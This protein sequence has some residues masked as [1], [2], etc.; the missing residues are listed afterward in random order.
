MNFVYPAFLFSLFL[1][2]IPV[3]IHLVNLRKYKKVYF[4]NVSLLQQIQTH[5][6]KKR[7]LREWLILAARVLFITFLV[8]AFAQPFIKQNNTANQSG[9]TYVSLYIDNSFSMEKQGVNGP[10]LAEAIRIAETVIKAY[11]PSDK[12]QILTNDFS[13]N[14]MR[15]L[16][17][18]EALA[19][20]PE[21]QTS[22]ALY[23]V[24]QV[25]KKQYDLLKTYSGGNN[26]RSYLISDFASNLMKED[27]F[28]PD[29]SL[30]IVALPVQAVVQNN[31][32]FDSIWCNSPTVAL[33]VPTELGFRVVNSGENEVVDQPIRVFVNGEQKTPALVTIPAKSK[34]NG[35]VTLNISK[36]GFYQ[37]YLE[38]DDASMSF[39]DRFFFS[40]EVKEKLQIGYVKGKSA[41]L[42]PVQVFDGDPQFQTQIFNE[43]QP[44]FQSWIDKDF[45]IV[46][47]ASTLSSGWGT[48]FNKF[49][50]KGGVLAIFPEPNSITNYNEVLKS[51]KLPLLQAEKTN[52]LKGGLLNAETPFFAGVFENKKKNWNDVPEVKRYF[53]LQNSSQTPWEVIFT[54]ANGDVAMAWCKVGNGY[55]LLSGLPLNETYSNLSSH[56]LFVPIMLKSAFYAQRIQNLYVEANSS[57]PIQFSQSSKN[58]ESIIELFH[59]EDQASFIPEQRV[60][61]NNLNLYINGVELKSGN[62]F[63]KQEGIDKGVLSVNF[64]PGEGLAEPI[65]VEQQKEWE[66]NWPNLKFLKS[67]DKDAVFTGIQKME[68][69]I[70]L[71]KYCLI[72][73]LLFLALEVI[74]TRFIK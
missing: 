74:F 26:I 35:T 11:K 15:F 27:A 1:I 59:P 18:E 70:S 5:S 2:A 68:K 12:F 19:T 20:L 58:S 44:D 57:S 30:S 17:R 31:V 32:G 62:Y 9:P 65:S 14:S 72:L 55:A 56:A 41:N 53:P 39:D 54:M 23:P 4:S 45:L 47:E 3:I 36:P 63:V 33:N 69:G 37:G 29:S 40:F 43:N 48:E 24:Q 7:Q 8:F 51:L 22:P 6:K 46:S 34:A 52:V 13:G 71:W 28:V 42:K 67:D 25:V 61:G 10:L 38:L 73:A 66:R 50:D 49:L 64:G 60:V 16:N 21:I